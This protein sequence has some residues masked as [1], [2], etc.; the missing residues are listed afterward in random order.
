M[1]FQHGRI[2]LVVG[3]TGYGKTSMLTAL[4]G[5][6]HL[7]PSGPTS[8][9]NLPHKGGVAYAAQESWVQ[10]EII[11]AIVRFDALYD[12]IRYN[13]V[14]YQCALKRDL[15]LFEAGDQTEVGEKGLTLRQAQRSEPSF[16]RITLVR[17]IYS[18][19][20]TLLLDDVLTALDVY[21]SKWIV[22]K[23]FAGDLAKDRM[24]IFVVRACRLYVT[25]L[26]L[27]QYRDITLLWQI[28]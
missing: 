11:R 15:T 10:N 14:L 3:P 9:F 27:R 7:T 25:T 4:L 5:E 21:R 28:L 13:T 20:N 23:C 22:G 12:E 26:F 16:A 18:S 8:W 24:V 6:M 17:A 1:Y 19:A 2:N